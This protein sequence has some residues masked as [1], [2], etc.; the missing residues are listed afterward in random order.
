[1]HVCLT[2]QTLFHTLS[3]QNRQSLFPT[4]VLRDQ[5]LRNSTA[6]AV[7][8][9]DLC[10]LPTH[11]VFPAWCLGLLPGMDHYLSRIPARIK[12]RLNKHGTTATDEGNA[13]RNRSMSGF[14]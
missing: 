8:A 9:L 14:A 4:L 3:P 1:M 7:D 12:R 5:P 13:V 6:G 2:H 10:R 11:R